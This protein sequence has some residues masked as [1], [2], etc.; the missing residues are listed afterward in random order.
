MVLA[1]LLAGLLSGCVAADNRQCRQV[2]R[3]YEAACREGDLESILKCIDKDSARVIRGITGIAGNLFA[4]EDEAILNRVSE[5]LF[6][7][8]F[9]ANFMKTIQFD[10][11]GIEVE[12]DETYAV[13]TVS[14]QNLLGSHVSRE[15]RITFTMEDGAWYVSKIKFI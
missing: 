1:C 13:G 2:I 6:G 3:D 4:V 7:L 9:V 15:I 5:V 11:D 10:I 8:D 12:N 14:Y